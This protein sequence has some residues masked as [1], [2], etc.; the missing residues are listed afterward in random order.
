MRTNSQ[1]NKTPISSQGPR[2]GVG[3]PCQAPTVIILL[4]IDVGVRDVKIL[5]KTWVSQC[6]KHRLGIQIEDLTP[7]Y[8]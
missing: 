8:G 2:P 3:A 1:R 4:R 7:I 5:S 6:I